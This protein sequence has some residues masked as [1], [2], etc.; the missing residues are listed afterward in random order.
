VAGKVYS[1]AINGKKSEALKAMAEDGDFTKASAS[2]IGE[3][4]AWIKAMGSA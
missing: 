3:L 4:R 2:L 1:L